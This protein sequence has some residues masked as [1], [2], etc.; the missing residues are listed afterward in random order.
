MQGI[1]LHLFQ[2]EEPVVWK[3]STKQHQELE[4]VVVTQVLANVVTMLSWAR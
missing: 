1:V 2:I 3:A 4:T